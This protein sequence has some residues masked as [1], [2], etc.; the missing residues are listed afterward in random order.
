LVARQSTIKVLVLTGHL[1]HDEIRRTL[2]ENVA[3][4]VLKPPDP[5]HLAEAIARAL[6]GTSP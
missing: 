6:V 3:G 4:W 1:L 2:P 5:E